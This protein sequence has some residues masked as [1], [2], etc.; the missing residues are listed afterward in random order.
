MGELN[1]SRVL[2]AFEQRG[3]RVRGDGD[4]HGELILS[5]FSP[6]LFV[7]RAGLIYLFLL[8]KSL[9]CVDLQKKEKK[10]NPLCERAYNIVKN[11]C[12]FQ[13]L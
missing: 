3:E 11:H 8:T 7:I 1:D 13:L 9:V 12:G 2:A 4:G 5:T 6:Q 10:M